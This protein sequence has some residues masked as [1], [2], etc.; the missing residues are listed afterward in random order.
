MM[1]EKNNTAAAEPTPAL[2][3][4]EIIDGVTFFPNIKAVLA[5]DSASDFR[6]DYDIEPLIKGKYHI[7]PWG[8]DNLL[9]NH[10]LKKSADNDIVSAN[11]KFNRDVCYGLG[12]KLIRVLNRKNGKITDFEEVTSGQEFDFFERNDIPL[13]V[14]SQL[15][16]MV[17]FYNTWSELHY[18]KDSQ[19][20]HTLRHLEAVFSRWSMMDKTG[21]IRFHYYAEWAKQNL[22]GKNIICTRALDEF[23]ALTELKMYAADK[24]RLVFSSYMPSPGKPYYSRPDW[25]SIFTSGWYDHSSM[26]PKLKKAILQ[27]QLGV[28][29]II[30][31]SPQYFD[32]IFK[33]EGID[34][35]DRKAV[36]ER[37]NKEKEAFARYLSG[38]ENANKAIMSLKTLTPTA[39]G[40]AAEQKW[41]EIVP[42]QN[43][44]KGGEYIDDT[45][46]T[47]NIIC[48]AMGVHS[49]L[50]GATPGKN[51]NTLGGS[52]ARE[53]YMMKQALMKPV[54]DRC[55]R[56]LKVIKEYNG[57][58]KDIMVT[59]PEYIFTTLDQNKSGK[60][61]STN[62]NV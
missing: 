34:K 35:N 2:A 22:D 55:L 6:L 47:A 29:Y 53:L 45:E 14:M 10:V 18:A 8:H 25:Y 56:V 15:T 37:V 12:P 40:N 38:E 49:A 41:V 21:D 16:D 52:N 48:Y 11:L 24:R 46:S 50:I 1:E 23:D 27:N 58:D 13:F 51:S 17:Q 19:K 30:Y 3:G 36:K 61:E 4:L 26:V 62:T 60:E 57:W 54:V 31:V 7:A 39:S 44:L 5:M 20:I 32:D 9:P 33:K 43:D 28:K 59:I 42:V